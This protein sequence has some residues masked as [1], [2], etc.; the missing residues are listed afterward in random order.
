MAQKDELFAKNEIISQKNDAIRQSIE[1]AKTIQRS[2]LPDLSIINNYFE[3]FLIYEPKDIVSGDFYW[4]CQS[5][6][7][8][9]YAVVDCTG[10]GVPGAFMSILA[11]RMLDEI[12][13]LKQITSPAK[14][15][16]ELNNIVVK[17]LK[18]ENKENNDGL[19]LIICRITIEEK[20]TEIFCSAVQKDL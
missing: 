18:Q 5:N 16:Y 13:L 8:H 9:F 17:T 12:V 15:L 20:M 10:H 2:I 6:N 11:S 4:Y 19:D 7:F 14:I 1:Y 3:N